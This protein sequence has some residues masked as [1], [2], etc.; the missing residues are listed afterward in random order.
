MYDV[1]LVGIWKSYS[2]YKNI[3]NGKTLQCKVPA[4]FRISHKNN[5][6]IC[7]SLNSYCT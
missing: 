5:L 1:Y 7:Y 4:C 6:I 3:W 2:M